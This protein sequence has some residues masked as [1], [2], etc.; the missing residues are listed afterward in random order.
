MP[1]KP[2]EPV[3]PTRKTTVQEPSRPQ[4]EWISW[5]V[6]L[7]QKADSAAGEIFKEEDYDNTK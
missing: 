2:V 3:Q 5:W 6:K 4:K 1:T 7:K